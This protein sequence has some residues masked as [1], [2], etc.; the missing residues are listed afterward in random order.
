MNVY[1]SVLTH[2]FFLDY[3][4]ASDDDESEDDGEICS[5]KYV[6]GGGDNDIDVE[7]ESGGDKS[8]IGFSLFK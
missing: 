1:N 2:S 4:R 6:G 8:L 5:F 7:V 3:E